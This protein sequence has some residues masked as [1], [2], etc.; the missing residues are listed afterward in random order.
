MNIIVDRNRFVQL[1]AKVRS[2]MRSI[3]E[4][5]ANLNIFVR[6]DLGSHIDQITAKYIGQWSTR[7]Y[8]VVLL[9]SLISL[10]LY[11]IIQPIVQTKYFQE[12]SLDLYN[13]L[14]INY[15][16]TLRCSCQSIASKYDQFIS[17][18]T[19]FH[20]VIN[21]NDFSMFDSNVFMIYLLDLYK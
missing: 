21:T 19:D 4:T 10:G 18:E 17:I 9:T 5:L 12:P 7:L 13:R 8:I 6:R 11:S 20:E 2:I 3:W 14:Y 15:G 16:D 1:K